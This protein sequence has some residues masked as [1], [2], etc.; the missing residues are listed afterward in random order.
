MVYILDNMGMYP[1]Q[2]EVL[3]T[4][5]DT[6]SLNMSENNEILIYFLL[7]TGKF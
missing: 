5:K 1:F 6:V 7:N 3:T 4:T 2:T